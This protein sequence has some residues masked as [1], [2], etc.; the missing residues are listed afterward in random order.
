MRAA[1]RN[2]VLIAGGGVA[3][4]EALLALQELAGPALEL[5]LLAPD[6]RFEYTPLSVA[7]PFGLGRAHSFEL[8]EILRDRGVETVADALEA[9]EAG[10]RR[11]RTAGGLALSYDALLVAIG[12]RRRNALFGAVTF[13][14]SRATAEIRRLLRKAVAAELERLVFAVPPGVTWSLP[15][16]ELALMTSA[17]L[18]E[19]QATAR[20]ALVTPEPRPVDAFGS[21]ASAAVEEM[22]RVR[23]IAFHS[24]L[25]VRAE[26]GL[27]VVEDGAAIPADAVVALPSMVAPRIPG[28]PRDE[29][30]FLPVDEHGRVPGPRGVYGAGDMTSFPLK[31]GG[32]AAQQADAAAAAI[33]ADLGLGVRPAPFR[34]VLRGLLLTG[35]APRFLRAEV[36]RGRV[37]RSTAAGE[38][39]WW[40]PSKIAGRRLGPFLAL[41][42]LAGGPPPDAVA[43]ELESPAARPSLSA[44]P[45][46][47]PRRSPPPR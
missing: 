18:A 36:L 21:R 41:R 16:Y 47:P 17:H 8:S 12:A 43:L 26:P 37:T 6:P 7:E 25:P 20:V 30:G 38:A 1:E 11:V 34:P 24:A 15:A 19:R 22:L 23:G 13:S 46:A 29:A 3:A 45:P 39:I 2:R 27:L 28:L 5:T 42:G 44:A 31:Q 40:P 10:E 35:R 33:A 32:I 4:L 14:G 9:V